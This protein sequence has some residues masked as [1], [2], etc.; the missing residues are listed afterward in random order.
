MIVVPS[1]L[2]CVTVCSPAAP[3][4]VVVAQVVAVVAQV[5]AVVAQ[6]AVVVARVAVV[7]ARV[8]EA[9]HYLPHLPLHLPLVA[10]PVV[11][12]AAPVAVS[13]EERSHLRPVKQAVEAEPVVEVAQHYLQHLHLHLPLVAEP[14]A[15]VVV[16]VQQYHILLVE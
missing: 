9:L 14:A 6:V 10:E 1:V 13:V 15:A 3:V 12:E 11:A 7:V 5:A 2:V 8:V 16:L 4:A